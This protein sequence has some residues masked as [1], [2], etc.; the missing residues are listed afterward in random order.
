MFFN[1][2]DKCFKKAWYLY[3]TSHKVM[4]CTCSKTIIY[5]SFFIYDQS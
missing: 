4:T 1:V 5:R 2:N 3:V